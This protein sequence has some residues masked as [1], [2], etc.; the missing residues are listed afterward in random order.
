LA[1]IR[2]SAGQVQGLQNNELSAHCK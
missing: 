1:T 2:H